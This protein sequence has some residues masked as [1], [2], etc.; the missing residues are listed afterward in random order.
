GECHAMR[1][2]SEALIEESTREGRDDE[3]FAEARALLAWVSDHHFTFLGYR[4]HE[5]TETALNPVEG[6]GLGLLR[7]GGTTSSGFAKLPL[8]VRALARE[9]DPLVLAKA[10]NR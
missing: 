7:G 10:N 3:E 6:S 9:P 4:E 2:R 1:E 5:L 8:G